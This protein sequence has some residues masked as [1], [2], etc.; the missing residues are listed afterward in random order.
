MSTYVV[1][2]HPRLGHRIETTDA[3]EV[4]ALIFA[5]VWLL[6]KGL[7]T[8][9]AL[10]FAAAFVT[11]AIG[12]VIERSAGSAGWVGLIWIPMIVLH[13]ADALH[14]RDWVRKDLQRRGFHP[15]AT[16]EAPTTDALLG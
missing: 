9:A 15:I 5:P 10:S 7:Y 12:A 16:I 14:G 8:A 1:F 13:F 4:P 11:F 2:E 3:N 6:L